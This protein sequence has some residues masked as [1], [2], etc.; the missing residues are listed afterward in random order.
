MATKGSRRWLLSLRLSQLLVTHVNDT[1]IQNLNHLETLVKGCK[2]K[3][4]P[5]SLLFTH[6]L[7]RLTTIEI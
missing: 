2:E 3:F 5:R 7:P 4:V 6:P 1:A